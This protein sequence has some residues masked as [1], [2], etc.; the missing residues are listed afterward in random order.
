MTQQAGKRV[1]RAGND[2]FR[3][4]Q[5]P[6]NDEIWLV[7]NWDFLFL[8]VLL[9]EFGGEWQTMSDYFRENVTS[10]HMRPS[11]EAKLSH[12][13]HLQETMQQAGLDP[14]S[15]LGPEA[16]A[17]LSKEKR[18]AVNKVINNFQLGFIDGYLFHSGWYLKSGADDGQSHKI[19]GNN[20]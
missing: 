7:S 1:I 3:E 20:T 9:N 12:L 19:A 2:L 6:D 17:L 14:I 18:H 11:V 10:L 16:T 8:V 5:R 13:R 15:V 4:V